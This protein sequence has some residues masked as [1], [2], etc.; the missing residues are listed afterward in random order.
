[1]RALFPA[2]AG[3]IRSVMPL[4]R[5]RWI[6]FGHVE[7]DECGAMNE[8]LAAAPHAQVA[9]GVAACQVSLNDL[10]DRPPRPLSNGKVLDIGGKL[11]HR[12]GPGDVRGGHRHARLR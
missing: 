1:M 12:A 2:V 9:S 3:A 11:L 6:A 8:F 7:A 4:E 5:L 10:C